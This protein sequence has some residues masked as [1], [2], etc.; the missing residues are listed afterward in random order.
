LAAPTSKR[1]GD[2]KASNARAPTTTTTTAAVDVDADE[3]SVALAADGLARVKADRTT[4]A[5]PQLLA[6][7]ARA[8]NRAVAGLTALQRH[9]IDGAPPR[10][11]EDEEL[12]RGA[13]QTLRLQRTWGAA[14]PMPAVSLQRWTKGVADKSAGPSDLKLGKGRPSVPKWEAKGPSV[15]AKG[16]KERSKLDLG[17]KRVDL[18]K[19]HLSKKEIPADG[20][21]SL[22]ASVGAKGRTILWSL[23]GPPGTSVDAKTGVV[24]AGPDAGG[25]DYLDVNVTATDAVM[26]SVSTYASFRLWSAPAWQAKVDLN[27]LLKLSKL[28]KKGV[29]TSANGKFDATYKPKARQLLVEVPVDFQFPDNPRTKGMSKRKL[30]ARR[31][32]LNQY[33]KDFTENVQN[34]WGGQFVFDMMREPKSMWGVLGPVDV[35]V[36]VR[37]VSKAA[38]YFHVIYQSKTAGRAGVGRPNVNLYQGDLAPVEAFTKS[39]KAGELDRLQKVSPPVRVEPDGSMGK[40]SQQS[41]EFLGTYVKRLGRPPITLKLTGKGFG[42]RDALKRAEVVKKALEQY[43]VGAPHKMVTATAASLLDR[44]VY[45]EPSVDPGF[46]NMQDVSAHEFGHMIGLPDEYPEDARVV[47]DKL[48]TYDRLL[49]AFGKDYAEQVGRV[50]DNTASIMHG[51]SQ[52]RIQHYVHFWD[53]LIMTS[54]L[55]AKAPKTKFGDADWKVRG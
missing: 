25:K 45:I 52:V 31:K 40:D 11:A 43:G 23:F 34:V 30:A 15:D 26:P 48:R 1:G 27:V 12:D 54:N 55:N 24:T 49:A 9:T 39:T 3:T 6:L 38:A 29:S 16:A 53:T 28:T 46:T 4:W 20:N 51:G 13:V 5:P 17:A 36:K 44:K 2:P 21:T 42:T 50:T 22:K 41:L 14:T 19:V 47:G 7:Q 32:E 33:R 37:E 10:P 35:S 18:G 8:G